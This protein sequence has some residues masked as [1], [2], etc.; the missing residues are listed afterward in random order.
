[1]AVSPL[2]NPSVSVGL[3]KGFADRGQ[4]GA[5][6]GLLESVR[7]EFEAVQVGV[8]RAAVPLDLAVGVS[9]GVRP[10]PPV[11]ARQAG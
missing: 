11:P 8:A 4:H 6:G 3:F 1:M 9:A 2:L 7:Q 10:D 5:V